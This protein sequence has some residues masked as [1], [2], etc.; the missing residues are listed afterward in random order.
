M[1]SEKR[2]LTITFFT[3]ATDAAS[4]TVTYLQYSPCP[5]RHVW[6]PGSKWLSLYSEQKT[7][8]WGGGKNYV[9]SGRKKISLLPDVGVRVRVL[10]AATET[11]ITPGEM[12]AL[13]YYIQKRKI[14]FC[15]C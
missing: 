11:I 15:A 10:R 5:A 13:Y 3:A 1:Y 8:F 14:F 6:S 12:E 9:F 4:S 2:V 7:F